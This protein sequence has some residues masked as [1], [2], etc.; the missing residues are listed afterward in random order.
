MSWRPLTQGRPNRI[1][2]FPVHTVHPQCGERL[3]QRR[4]TAVLGWGGWSSAWPAA[5]LSCTYTTPYGV[6]SLSCKPISLYIL[7]HHQSAFY[8]LILHNEPF[9]DPAEGL[10]FQTS[11][12]GPTPVTVI[13]F[14]SLLDYFAT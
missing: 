3:G 10:R 1:S 6:D 9:F 8:Y 4:I 5:I 2:A 14:K 7:K 13:A 11:P 12:F